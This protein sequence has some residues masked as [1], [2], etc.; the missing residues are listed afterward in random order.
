MGINQRASHLFSGD[1]TMSNGLAVD[2]IQAS[3][4]VQSEDLALIPTVDGLT[5]GLIPANQSVVTATSAGANNILTLPAG[6]AGLIGMVCDI[7]PV[8]GTN[9]ELRT[10]DSG[11]A[12]V[13]GIA[14]DGAKEALLVS[15][16]AYQ[17]RLI[18]VDRWLLTGLTSLGAV[19]TAVIP[20]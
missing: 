6:V 10:P 15:G 1:V 18:A 17:V 5:T 14:A 19:L 3:V 20:D 11:G 2:T 9:C 16:N 8:G 4:G 12:T 7:Y 13:N